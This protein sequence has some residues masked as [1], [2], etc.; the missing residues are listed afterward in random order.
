M[1]LPNFEIY[2]K[3]SGLV[4]IKEWITLSNQRCLTLEGHDI[5]EGWHS[6]IWYNI[7]GGDTIFKKHLIRSSLLKI[8]NTI[9]YRMYEKTPLWITPVEAFKQQNLMDWHKIKTYKDR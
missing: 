2:Y 9:K 1:G 4:W 8:W 6:Y 3:A 5:L 7:A